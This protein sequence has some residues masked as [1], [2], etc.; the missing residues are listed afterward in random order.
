M[1]TFGRFGHKKDKEKDQKLFLE[2]L[3]GL[4]DDFINFLNPNAIPSNLSEKEL[5]TP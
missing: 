4:L 2:Y 3:N 1:I 5:I